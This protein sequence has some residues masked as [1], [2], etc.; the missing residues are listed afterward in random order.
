MTRY[1]ALMILP[2]VLSA[3]GADGEPEPVT[4]PRPAAVEPAPAPLQVSGTARVGVSISTS[5]VHPRAG[6]ALTQGPWTLGLGF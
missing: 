2:F 3:C 1:A 5:G 4:A 6:V